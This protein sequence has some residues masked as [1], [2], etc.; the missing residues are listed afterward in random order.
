MNFDESNSIGGHL[1]S[2]YLNMNGNALN[3]QITYTF[4][5]IFGRQ[6]K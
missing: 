2:I 4:N 5:S 3:G 6:S 1:E